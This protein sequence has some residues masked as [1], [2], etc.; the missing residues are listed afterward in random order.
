MAGQI[1]ADFVKRDRDARSMVRVVVG[2]TGASGAIYGVRLLMALRTM[3]VETHLV[4][5]PPAEITLEQEMRMK[6][7]TVRSL[8]DHA[9]DPRDLSAPIAS[10]SFVTAGMIVAPCTV[11]T[12]SAIAHSHADT[13]L[14]RAADVM[15][16]EGRPLILVVREAPLHLGHLRL[17]V[18]AAEIGAVIFPPV[19]AFYTHPA[20]IEEMVDQ[21]VGRM[22]LRLGIPNDLYRPW[23]GPA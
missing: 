6:P 15:L 17:M 11:K 23:E 14:T 12:L 21:S 7:E 20:T 16:K 9:Y 19:P 13:L 3:A 1:G 8:A 4:L 18:Q 5:T 2:M 22:L 10:G